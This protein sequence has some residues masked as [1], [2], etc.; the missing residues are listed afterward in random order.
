MHRL[1]AQGDDWGWLIHGVDEEGDHN[2]LVIKIELEG[3]KVEPLIVPL[4][5]LGIKLGASQITES[6]RQIYLRAA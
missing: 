4:R 6:F 5:E 2:P 1:A 3:S